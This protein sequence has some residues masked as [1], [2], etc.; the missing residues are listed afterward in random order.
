MLIF[1]MKFESNFWWELHGVDH[2]VHVD[3]AKSSTKHTYIS[4]E[5]V[6]PSSNNG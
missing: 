4:I 6:E 3:A 1:T 2:N 5:V